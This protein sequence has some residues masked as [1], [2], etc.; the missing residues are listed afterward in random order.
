[1]KMIYTTA[2]VAPNT[3]MIRLLKMSADKH[4]I[5]LKPY[6]IGGTYAEWVD[7]KI[8]K[9]CAAA[10]TWLDEGYTHVF[11]TD[12]RDSLFLAGRDEIERKYEELG[13]PPYLV[14]AEDQAYPFRHL[15]EKFPDPGHPWRYIGAGQFMGGIRFMLDLW[16]RLRELYQNIPEEN[17]DQGWLQLAYAEGKLDLNQFKIDTDCKIFQTASV[18]RMG[19]DVPNYIELGRLKID[20]A[21]VYNPITGQ[22]PCAIHLPGGYADPVTGKERVI[23]PLYE[24]LYGK[25][26]VS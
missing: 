12:G 7:I 25:F 3:N 23:L 11:Y 18:E 14:S 21:R 13:F 24:A 17:H 10:K 19:M 15:A 9:F 4:K 22:Y 2:C 8:T 5:P 6:G 1:M 20:V 26:D 16:P